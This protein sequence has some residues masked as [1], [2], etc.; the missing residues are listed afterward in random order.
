MTTALVL[1][2]GGTRG[3]FQAGAVRALYNAGIRPDIICATSAGALSAIKLA[4]GSEGEGSALGLAGLEHLWARMQIKTDMYVEES[5]LYHEDMDGAFRRMLIRG[6]PGP[7]GPGRLGDDRGPLDFIGSRWKEFVWWA[8][9]AGR[10]L[11]TSFKL[12]AEARSLYRLD[13]I[14]TKLHQGVRLEAVAGWAAKGG[15]LRISVVGLTCGRLRYVTETGAV[16]ERDGSPVQE[17]FRLNER[18]QQLKQEAEEVRGELNQVRD[19]LPPG[20]ARNAAIARLRRRLATVLAQL[21]AEPKDPVPLVVPLLDGVLASASIPMAF[22]PVRLGADHYVDGGALENVP[23]QAAVDLGAEITYVVTLAPVGSSPDDTDYAN[24]KFATIAART[25][26]LMSGEV[27]RSDELLRARPGTVMASTVHHIRPDFLLYDTTVVDSGLIQIARDYGYM[28]AADVLDGADPAG[29]TW[30]S[31][32]E[33]TQARIDVWR[34]ENWRHGQDDPTDYEPA[35]PADPGLDGPI[36]ELKTHIAALVGARTQNGGRVPDNLPTRIVDLELHPWLSRRDDASSVSQI[37]D[38]EPSP[39]LTRTAIVTVRND[40][41]MVWT[42]EQ[43]YHLGSRC[44]PPDAFGLTRVDLAGSVDPG[45]LATFEFTVRTPT[46][47]A[48][49]CWQMR[50]ADEWFGAPTAKIR[51]EPPSPCALLADQAADISADIQS[52]QTDLQDAPPQGKAA[53]VAAIRRVQARLA[54]VERRRQQLGCV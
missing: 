26:D 39:G 33:I 44:D 21:N 7:R 51:F 16:L 8:G 41:R 42:A 32:T 37:F 48:S 38:G 18:A 50:R 27:S 10:K 19:Y 22:P 5:W 3:A 2:G 29:G 47:R 15:R 30:R 14:Q 36:A 23:L 9:S 43:G 13:P 12:L 1:G 46:M 6:G 17:E 49:W 40:G 31:A 45:A 28:R 52:L 35:P 4:E 34:L 20:A 11:P 54:E 25:V 24:A 53:I